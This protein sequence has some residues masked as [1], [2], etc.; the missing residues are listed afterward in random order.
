ME[1]EKPTP[2]M[3]V[4]LGIITIGIYLVYWNFKTAKEIYN[5]AQWEGYKGIS[6]Q[7]V[8]CLICSLIPFGGWLIS[9][10]LIQTNINTLHFLESRKKLSVSGE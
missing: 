2:G 3:V 4:F 1:E 5:Y 10:G 7:S 8:L 9:M 6:D